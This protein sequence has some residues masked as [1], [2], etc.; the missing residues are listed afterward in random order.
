MESVLKV[1]V[2]QVPI[3]VRV[4]SRVMGRT[5]L[6]WRTP[7]TLELARRVER[8]LAPAWIHLVRLAVSLL[9][10]EAVHHVEGFLG[11]QGLQHARR[12]PRAVLEEHRMRQSASFSSP[13]AYQ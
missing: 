3:A 2:S 11:W 4:T 8:L 12:R 10:R 7:P 6:R 5:G 13:W 1:R 9:A